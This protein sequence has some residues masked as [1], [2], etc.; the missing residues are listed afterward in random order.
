[1]SWGHRIIDSQSLAHFRCDAFG[2]WSKERSLAGNLPAQLLPTTPRPC[3]HCGKML[4]LCG[5][6][7][8]AISKVRAERFGGWK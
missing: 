2:V 7:L 5:G 6:I 4:E 3:R 8:S 1:M